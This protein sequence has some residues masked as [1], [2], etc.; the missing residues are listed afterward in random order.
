MSFWESRKIKST[1]KKHRC[2]YCRETIPVGSG[3]SYEAGVWDSEFNHY[4]LCDRCRLFISMYHDRGDDSLGE[5]DDELF[6]TDLLDCPHCGSRNHRE[7]EYH[8]RKQSIEIEC[9]E[10]DRLYVVDLS[11]EAFKQIKDKPGQ[12][13]R[14]E[15]WKESTM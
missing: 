9:D 13:R 3:C 4:Y 6:E 2:E 8:H 1:R 14:G 12:A 5:F 7:Y 15:G 11:Y 10:C